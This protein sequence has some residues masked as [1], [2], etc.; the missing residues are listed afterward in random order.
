MK[1]RTHRRHK[2]TQKRRFFSNKQKT[3][4]RRAK[5]HGGS[6]ETPMVGTL[7]GEPHKGL[8]TIV[9]AGPMGVMSG[10]SFLK[11]KEDADRDGIDY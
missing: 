6:L 5:K 1:P 4:K 2:R 8:H 11:A 9:V 7:E 3:Q 10:T